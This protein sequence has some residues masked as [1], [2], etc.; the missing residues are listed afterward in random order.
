MKK[1]FTTSYEKYGTQI[2]TIEISAS[3]DNRLFL[4]TVATTK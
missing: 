4:I 1:V 3:S 2:I